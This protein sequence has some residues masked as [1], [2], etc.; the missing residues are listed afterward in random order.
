MS[1]AAAITLP[2]VRQ[3]SVLDAALGPVLAAALAD[4]SVAEILI[5]ADGAIWIE[6]AGQGLMATGAHMPASDRET[7]IRL[8]AHASAET[9]GPGRPL[10][11]ASLPGSA[12]RVQAVLPPLSE[13]PVLAIRCRP[14]RI[15]TLKDYVAAGIASAGEAA[16]LR[17]ALD[18]RANII[19]A[20]G[21]GS[22][23]TTLLNALLAEPVLAGGRLIVLED[24]PEL[25]VSGD[26]SVQLL[27]RR[28]DPEVTLRDLVQAAL[29]LRPDRI[30]AGEVR[31]G[32]ALDVL[33]A[34]NTGHPGGLLTLHANSARDALARLEDLC[35][36]A[37]AASPDRLIASAVDLIVFIAR[38]GE[39]RRITELV[40][41]RTH[42]ARGGTE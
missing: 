14:D 27:T 39:G 25:Q 2:A 30:I 10:L 11:S 28:A 17:A 34:W 9:A 12:A 5:N 16:A 3:R 22:G 18:E 8:L 40:D 33:K 4:P 36:E 7:V 13:A 26:N 21:A 23:K 20:G 15:L 31:D 1:A 35:L 24:T 38:T 41:S 19:V 37:Q 32:A 42:P 29:R 6:R